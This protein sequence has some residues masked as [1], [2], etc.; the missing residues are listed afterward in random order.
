MKAHEYMPSRTNPHRRFP[1]DVW[2]G[3]Y[4]TPCVRAGRVTYDVDYLEEEIYPAA[5]CM[6]KR[7]RVSWPGGSSMVQ[8]VCFG[9]WPDHGV[10]DDPTILIELIKLVDTL[11]GKSTSL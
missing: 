6:V 11:A 9:D 1:P 3:Q 4:G 8:Q 5:G 2:S 7:V 10:P